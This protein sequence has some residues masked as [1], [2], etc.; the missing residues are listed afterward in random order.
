MAVGPL[1]LNIIMALAI[2]FGSFTKSTGAAPAAQSFPHGLGST[3]KVLIMWMSSGLTTDSFVTSFRSAF[4]V[5][6][7]STN[8]K[9]VASASINAGASSNASKRHASK[10]LTVVQWGETLLAEADL[11]SF[12]GT[13]VNLSWT[14]NNAVAYIIHF[15]VIGGDDL[16]NASVL[17]WSMPIVTGNNSQTGMGFQP[18]FVLHFFT[19]SSVAPPDS[20]T[21]STNGIGA[22]NSVGEQWALM[23]QSQDNQV[24]MVTDRGQRTD[25]TLLRYSFGDGSAP[26]IQASFVSM[27]ADGFTM[28]FT[29]PPGAAIVCFSLGLKGGQYKIGASNKPTGAAPVTQTFPTT[30]TP[31]GYFIASFQDVTQPSNVSRAHNRLGLGGSDG[32]SEQS[33]AF[34][35]TDALAVSSV[36]AV[37]STTKVFIKV[38]NDTAT[39]D[40]Q[41]DHSSLG[42]TGPVINWTTNDAVATEMLYLAFGD[43]AGAAGWG[44]LLGQ[45]RNRLVGLTA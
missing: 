34:S 2:A 26:D 17:Q 28:N 45:R 4:G 43:T 36:D 39:I 33:T 20:K 41:A 10:A 32:T 12:D 23:S 8:F 16:T 5:A 30:F 1:F 31:K 9:S 19:L 18:D 14:T 24:T 15:C 25:S 37:D 3:P 21:S 35:D 40:A 38:N 7:S 44:P 11:S 22:M 29:T 27:D 6:T 13:N 42:A